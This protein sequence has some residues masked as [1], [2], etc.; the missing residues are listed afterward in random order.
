MSGRP[1]TIFAAAMAALLLLLIAVAI[2][3]PAQG[4]TAGTLD[5]LAV[6]VAHR[7]GCQAWLTAHPGSTS[8]RAARMRTCVADDTEI[9]NALTAAQPSPTPSATASASPQ[10]S[11]TGTASPSPT[12][13]PTTPSPS[14]TPS[15]G[16]PTPSTT[17][18]P[19]G[20]VLTDDPRCTLSTPG[21]LIVAHHFT[22]R[23]NITTYVSIVNSQLDA[24]IDDWS[25]NG[26]F[27]LTDSTIGSPLACD[28]NFG[29]GA[30]AFTAARVKIWGF[31]DGIRLSGLNT[32]PISVTDS[33]VLTCDVPGA[34]GDG[35]QELENSAPVTLRH[36]TIDLRP[37]CP[38]LTNCDWTAAV[39][40]PEG[41]P[42]TLADN[43]LAGGGWT[44]QIGAGPVT[45]T[46]NR[47]VDG[48]W[49]YGPVSAPCSAVTWSGNVAVN[50]DAAG[51]PGPA[52][53]TVACG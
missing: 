47:F 52:L 40:W 18:V 8:S 31:S 10:P 30:T 27:T 44:V 5:P 45:A 9:I 13:V 24:G 28:G 19:A 14:P 11:P 37:V 43:V 48:S 29:L 49:E 39:F 4:D 50:L 34:H 38:A 51:Q 42:L 2:S 21:E 16:W 32:T 26:S 23:L 12:P 33:Y 15:G 41:G 25:G 6:A 17:G 35:A 7:A 53:R 22:C 46:G 3:A 1:R 20:T 36:N